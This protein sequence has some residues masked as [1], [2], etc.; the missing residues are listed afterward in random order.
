MLPLGLGL[1]LGLGL[2]LLCWLG[3]K[4]GSRGRRRGMIDFVMFFWI[5][6]PFTI[7][8]LSWDGPTAYTILED[9]FLENCC[10]HLKQARKYQ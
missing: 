5:Y 1:G 8:F 10:S 3:L 9:F 2:R 4:E 6:W 7:L